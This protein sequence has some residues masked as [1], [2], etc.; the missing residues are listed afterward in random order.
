MRVLRFRA[1][2]DRLS[3]KGFRSSYKGV[4]T[5]LREFYLV[6]DDGIVKVLPGCLAGIL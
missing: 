2:T 3:F 1:S 6:F 5:T 4:I